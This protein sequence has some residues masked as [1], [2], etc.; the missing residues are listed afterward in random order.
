VNTLVVLPDGTLASGAG[1]GTIRLWD[2]GAGAAS[3]S[4]EGHTLAVR[5]LALLPDGRLA[6]AS[7]DK[8]ILLWDLRSCA[9][10]RRLTGHKGSIPALA[11]LADGRLASYSSDHM[12]ALWDPVNGKGA[13]ALEM[14]RHHVVMRYGDDTI[15]IDD[16]SS[17]FSSVRALAVLPDGRLA[18]GSF[19]HTIRLWEP[20]SRAKSAE[21]PWLRD[22]MY[23]GKSSPGFEGHRADVVVLTVLPDGRLI[24]GSIDGTIRLWDIASFK[25]ITRL[26]GHAG[27][28][29]TLALLGDGRLASGGTDGTVRLWDFESCGEIWCLGRHTGPVNSVVALPDG[30]LLSGAD[31]RTVRL[32]DLPTGRE[33]C[34]LEVDAAVLCLAAIPE[35]R[36]VAGDQLGSVAL[37]RYCGLKQSEDRPR[38]PPEP[39]PPERSAGS[40]SP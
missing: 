28:I 31:D 17:S 16:P 10:T 21:A 14:G 5:A 37:A 7:D 32:W 2:S 9:E 27:P 25:E 1:D 30:K 33:A 6:S 26:E 20:P 34:R 18:L 36:I 29:K 35:D 15:E 23:Y 39:P 40:C 4:S 12:V 8:S 3:A 38:D 11:V 24:S 13:G 19:D 22:T